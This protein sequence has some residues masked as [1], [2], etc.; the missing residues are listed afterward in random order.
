MHRIPPSVTVYP[1]LSDVTHDPILIWQQLTPIRARRKTG[2]IGQNWAET[3]RIGQIRADSGRNG[4]VWAEAGSFGQ[5]GQGV[6]TRP[7]RNP[8]KTTVR[9]EVFADGGSVSDA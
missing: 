1:T 3:G 8:D 2:R 6:L 5:G 7:G 9:V 4:Q